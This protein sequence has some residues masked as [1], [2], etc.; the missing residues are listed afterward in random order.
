MQMQGQEVSVSSEITIREQ[1]VVE[2]A[3]PA[4]DSDALDA[5]RRIVDAAADLDV[6]FTNSG[7]G[8]SIVAGLIEARQDAKSEAMKACLD[9]ASTDAAQLAASSGATLGRVVKIDSMAEQKSSH[10]Q[11][12][13]M[14]GYG[15]YMMMIGFD[16]S[17]ASGDD[18]DG[19]SLTT[20]RVVVQAT[21]TYELLYDTPSA[22]AGGS[23]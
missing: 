1:L 20:D 6:K 13:S 16:D 19:V 22:N 11:Q 9:N 18:L 2:F 4:N 12:D 8:G 7:P 17:D 23:Q 5:V 10:G 14:N 15:L 3:T 21:V